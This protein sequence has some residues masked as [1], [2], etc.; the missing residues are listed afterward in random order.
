[1]MVRPLP[2]DKSVGIA[3]VAGWAPGVGTL[4]PFDERNAYVGTR[5]LHVRLV[6]CIRN[7]PNKLINQELQ[8]WRHGVKQDL[9]SYPTKAQERE[10]KMDIKDRL[11]EKMP[12]TR[13]ESEVVIDLTESVV[14]T[15]TVSGKAYEWLIEYL[16][17]A[18]T[19]RWELENAAERLHLVP[20]YRDGARFFTTAPVCDLQDWPRA[21]LT[22]VFLAASA[23]SAVAKVRIGVQG[24]VVL[25]EGGDEGQIVTIK[26]GAPTMSDEMRTALVQGKTLSSCVLRVENTTSTWAWEFTIDAETW[27]ISGLKPKREQNVDEVSAMESRWQQLESVFN[28]L[29]AAVD[30]YAEFFQEEGR[31][32]LIKLGAEWYA[33]EE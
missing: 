1:M 31:A 2:K 29:H 10:Q 19:T 27:S 14:Y 33:R 11:A 28:W 30:H 20:A 25:K 32:G 5:Y 16:N 9:G 13:S 8:K 18:T 21:F 24:P 22:W 26:K 3:M 12:V 17:E 6:R 7:V 4:I 15:D 23:G